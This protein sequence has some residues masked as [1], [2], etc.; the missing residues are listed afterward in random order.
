MKPLKLLN[1]VESFGKCKACGKETILG[2]GFC[3]YCWDGEERPKKKLSTTQQ[4]KQFIKYW[5]G[6]NQCKY[7]DSTRIIKYG[8]HRDKDGIVQRYYCVECK[9]SFSLNSIRRILLRREKR[10]QYYAI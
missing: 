4:I 1:V 9:R 6:K 7:C 3:V 8:R 2:N 5:Q 10:R